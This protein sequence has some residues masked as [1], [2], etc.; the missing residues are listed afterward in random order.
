M[1]LERLELSD[2]RNYQAFERVFDRSRVILLGDNAQGKTNLLE[3][4][5]SL[6]TAS[7]PFTNRE[8]DLVRWGA[9]QAIVRSSVRKE[10]GT[11]SVDLLFRPAG[12]RAVKVNGLH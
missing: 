11:V 4:I 5:A 12:R 2:F 7:S 6:A 8:A 10:T 9:P 1:F 3:A